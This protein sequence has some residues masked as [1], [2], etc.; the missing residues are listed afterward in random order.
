MKRSMPR[1]PSI[2]GWTHTLGMGQ[3]VRGPGQSRAL[4]LPTRRQPISHRRESAIRA[5][6]D[7]LN[8]RFM[9]LGHEPAGAFRATRVTTP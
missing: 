2:G 9:R 5:R 4:S 7:E 6:L 8:N 3:T 1:L